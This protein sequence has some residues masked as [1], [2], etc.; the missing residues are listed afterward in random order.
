[1][2]RYSYRITRE[3]LIAAQRLF[4]RHSLSRPWAVAFWVVSVMILGLAVSGL[5]LK[6][7]MHP[8]VLLVAFVSPLALW[9]IAYVL[10]P[11]CLGLLYGLLQYRN[12]PALRHLVEVE[13]AEEGLVWHQGPDRWVTAWSDYI[14]YADN[15]E[16]VL[17]YLSP[18]LFHLLPKAELSEGAI[19]KVKERFH[20]TR[21][22]V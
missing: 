6:E 20:A 11:P 12:Y 8:L 7:V 2:E 19:A 10:L 4:V 14:K 18:R 13:I 22:V 5:P 1:M 3:R 15:H 17:L 9:L 16:I 21:K